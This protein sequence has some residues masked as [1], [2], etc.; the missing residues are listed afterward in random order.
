MYV[1]FLF[2]NKF[3]KPQLL[4]LLL[5][6]TLF[7][8]CKTVPIIRDKDFKNKQKALIDD[9]KLYSYKEKLSEDDISHLASKIRVPKNKIKNTKLNNFVRSWEETTYLYGGTDKNGIDCSS[10]MIHLYR[11]VF[12]TYLPRT[13]GEMYEDERFNY[14]ESN[15]KL[16]E[17]DLVFFKIDREKIVSHV[18]VYLKNDMFFSASSTEGCNITSLKAQYWKKYYVGGSRLK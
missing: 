13:S 8:S 3:L 18:G 7:N 14:I 16:M 9:F 5:V 15:Q 1:I 12:D 4:L 2:M 10:L 6:I 17:G 11:Y